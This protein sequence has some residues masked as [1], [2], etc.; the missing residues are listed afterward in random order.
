VAEAE[1]LV[2]GDKPAVALFYDAACICSLAAAKS[3]DSVAG[4][5]Y[6]ARAVALLAQ[7][8]ARGYFKE[9]ARVEKLKKDADLDPLR[10][11]PDFQ[12]LLTELGQ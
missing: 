9:A 8:H 5:Q 10:G 7:A 11:R 3:S 4:D 2:A 12:K 1:E 6:A